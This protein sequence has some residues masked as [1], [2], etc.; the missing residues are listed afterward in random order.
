LRFLLLITDAAANTS[1]FWKSLLMSNLS[2][3]RFLNAT[4]RRA[5]SSRELWP[6][7]GFQLAPLNSMNP[8]GQVWVYSVGWSSQLRR[9]TPH[10]CWLLGNFLRCFCYHW[11]WNF[12]CDIFT[13]SLSKRVC[14]NMLDLPRCFFWPSLNGIENYWVLG[15]LCFQTHYGPMFGGPC[16]W[17]TQVIGRIKISRRNWE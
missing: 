17:E 16:D 8:F 1:D 6:V 3:P 15:V 4:F 2:K 12:G 11:F 13:I 5:P 14:P 9:E 7:T 10:F